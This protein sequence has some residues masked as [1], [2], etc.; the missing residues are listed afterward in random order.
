MAKMTTP[1]AVGKVSY[2]ARMSELLRE[3]R[4]EEARQFAKQLLAASPK[5]VNPA[6]SILNDLRNLLHSFE[7]RDP[8][9]E[10]LFDP[11]W[12]RLVNISKIFNGDL[13]AFRADIKNALLGLGFQSDA[14]GFG[15]VDGAERLVLSREALSTETP[16]I[17]NL[18]AIVAHVARKYLTDCR[19]NGY[20]EAFMR[21]RFTLKYFAH[22]TRNGGHHTP[23]VHGNA[24]FV[25]AYYVHVPSDTDVEL[26]FGGYE[27][28]GL[29]ELKS[30]LIA[31]KR[32]VTGD[33]V[34]F[35]GFLSHTTTPN[36]GSEMRINMAFDVQPA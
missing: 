16:A 30:P 10:N 22:A 13:D 32:P 20:P 1:G 31:T 6:N 25:V 29:P 26:Q 9:I 36:F 4:P 12:I 35:P 21:D 19:A 15:N 34:V 23:H 27:R 2:E 11:R 17:D 33:F 18:Q 8:E 24:M 7:L 28:P 5:F 3:G 14:P